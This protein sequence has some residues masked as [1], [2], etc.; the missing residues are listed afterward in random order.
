MVDIGRRNSYHPFAID[1]MNIHSWEM[2]AKW[3]RNLGGIR[4]ED[5]NSHERSLSFL[6]WRHI[7]LLEAIEHG[8][9]VLTH[10]YAHWKSQRNV[11]I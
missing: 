4:I 9:F 6:P 10:K 8:V 7:F 3:I 2:M 1:K 5:A 11:W